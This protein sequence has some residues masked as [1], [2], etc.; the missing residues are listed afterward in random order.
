MGGETMSQSV[1]M[2]V[3]VLESCPA[4]RTPAYVPARLVG[5]RLLDSTMAVTARE[6]IDG[7]PL[8][9]RRPLGAPVRAQRIEQPG[10]EHDVT[11]LAPLAAAYMDDHAPAIDIADLE[12]GYLGAAPSGRIECHEHGTPK[13]GSG[14]LDLMR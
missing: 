14:P 11:V 1:G 6:Q 10:T 4:S 2:D 5:D 8:G 9:A 3:P 13:G 7:W 12:C